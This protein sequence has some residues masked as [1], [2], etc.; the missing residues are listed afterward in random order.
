MIWLQR[1]LGFFVGFGC[2]LGVVFLVATTFGWDNIWEKLVGPPDMGVVEFEGLGKRSSPNQALVCPDGVCK[3]DDRDLSSPLYSVDAAQLRARV[4]E[5]MTTVSDAERLDDDSDPLRLRYLTRSRLMRFP[6]TTDIAFYN[7]GDGRSTLAI[8]A[9][10][11]IGK[12]DF[13]ANL[14]RVKKLLAAIDDIT[15]NEPATNRDD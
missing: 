13:G 12:T 11:Q 7:M 8:Y 4:I 1:I 3:D 9:R 10:A 14:A 15:I 2:L 5:A 6:D